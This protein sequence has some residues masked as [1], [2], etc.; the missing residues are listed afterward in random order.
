MPSSLHITPS[1]HDFNWLRRFIILILITGA[2]RWCPVS[3]DNS[4]EPSTYY[5]HW[6]CIATYCRLTAV[7]FI[8][9]CLAGLN[10]I[11]GHGAN[12]SKSLDRPEFLILATLSL[13]LKY[14]D[15]FIWKFE[16]QLKWKWKIAHFN[17]LFLLRVVGCGTLILLCRGPGVVPLA[18]VYF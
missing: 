3:T 4:D 14:I 8:K 15:N 16:W 18:S 6:H 12:E 11:Y 10:N 5:R 1:V 7:Q 2:A 17:F 9:T 13:Y